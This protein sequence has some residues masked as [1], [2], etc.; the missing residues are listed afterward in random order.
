MNMTNRICWICDREPESHSFSK[1]GYHLDCNIFYS[2]PAKATKY[3]DRD[4]I[5]GHYDAT[6]AYNGDNPWIWIFD[7]SGFSLKHAMEISVAT[8]LAKL[9]EEKYS[10]NLEK[11]YIIN[12]NW[13]INISINVVWPFLSTATR[14][15]IVTNPPDYSF[16][17]KYLDNIYNKPNAL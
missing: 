7:C 17:K 14:S 8:G 11:I 1:I 4:G 3:Y 16:V 2:C 5:L 13:W 12:S 10:K 9:L 15:R 6:L